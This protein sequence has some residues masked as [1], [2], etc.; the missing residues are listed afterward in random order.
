M[1][2]TKYQVVQV[3]SD[4][5]GEAGASTVTYSVNGQSYS[6]DLTEV[7]AKAFHEMLAPYIAVSAIGK[8]RGPR[9]RSTPE[10]TAKIRTWAKK[11]GHTLTPAGRVPSE[12]RQAYAEAMAAAPAAPTKKAPAKKS[13]PV[14]K[15]PAKKAPAK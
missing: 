9:L 2:T 12:V 6:I 3:L 15:A 13:A 8:R 1:S 14:K 10:E 4:V 11:N 5:S 7:E